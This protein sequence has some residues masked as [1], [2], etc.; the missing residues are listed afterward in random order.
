MKTTH[1]L[2]L[3]AFAALVAA[4]APLIA[5]DGRPLR[6][7]PHGT[8]QCALP[9]DADG[10]AYDVV[11]EEGFKIGTSSRYTIATGGGTYLMRGRELVFTS[12]PKKGEQFKRVGAN[13]LQR[14]KAD[15]TLSQL[16]CT[17][18]GSTG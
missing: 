11:E 12:G 17:R 15:G 5:Q 4:A 16:R 2:M 1:V 6:T 13:Q 9:G 7:M 8:Y 18:L 3:T 10:L 14:M